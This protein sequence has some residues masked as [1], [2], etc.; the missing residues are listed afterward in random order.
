MTPHSAFVETLNSNP[1]I[2]ILTLNQPTYGVEMC[3]I[4]RV[5][6]W[7]EKDQVIDIL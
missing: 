2:P 6:T 4:K 1:S 5:T 3:K 7:F